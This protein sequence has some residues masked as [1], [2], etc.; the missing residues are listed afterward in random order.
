MKK[1]IIRPKSDTAGWIR[2]ILFLLAKCVPSVTRIEQNMGSCKDSEFEYLVV[3][4]VKSE[5]LKNMEIIRIRL[6]RKVGNPNFWKE[7][8]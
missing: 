2:E 4:R 8:D 5:G 3:R 6:P 1:T 7:G